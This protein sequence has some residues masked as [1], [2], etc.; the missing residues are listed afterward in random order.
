MV[1]RL[2]FS[3]I[4]LI[5]FFSTN[6]YAQ[7]I[8]I[9][10]R[11]VDNTG[12]TL[13]NCT[14]MLYDKQNN[15]LTSG[16]ISDTDGLFA[17]RVNTKGSY[18]L[19]ISILGFDKNI[20]HL[21]VKD[22][23]I[24]I[25]N[26]VLEESAINLS[27]VSV[28]A[29][30]NE[31]EFSPGKTTVNLSSPLSKASSNILDVLKT[32]PGV[33]IREDGTV[34]LNGQS[35]SQIIVNGK[36]TYLSGENL[37]NLL[38]SMPATSVS[39]IEL[40]THPSAQYDAAGNSGII[41]LHTDRHFF[42]GSSLATHARYTQG[43]YAGGDIGFNFAYRDGKLCLFSD[44]SYYTGKG[45]NDLNVIRE[46]LDFIT[47]K[48]LSDK[49]MYQDT[50]R[51][52]KY[53]SHY[54]RVGLDYDIS[55]KT[56]LGIYSNGFIM[57][58]R[59]DGD[60]SSR[61]VELD[62]IL[63]SELLTNNKN[64]KYPRSYTGGINM[65][66]KPEKET[67]WN[68]YF[69]F[70]YHDQPENQFQYDTF[71]D[72]VSGEQKQD[73]LKGDMGGKIHIYAGESNISFPISKSK[74]RAGAKTSFI[75]VDNSTVYHNLYDNKWLENEALSRQFSYSENINAAYLQAETRFSDRLSTQIGLRVE[76]TN[77]RGT[78]SSYASD[79]DSSY[80]HHYTHLFPSVTLEYKFQ[81]G[82]ALSALYSRRINRPNYNDMNP[83]VYIFDNYMHEQGNPDLEPSLSDN[84]ELSFVWKNKLK[85]SVFLLHVKDPISKSFHL[86]ENDRILVYP[87]NLSSSYSYGLRLNSS[88]FNP[89][90]WW[91]VSA[92][93]T[94][95]YKR[96]KWFFFDKEEKASV[97]SPYAGL[98]N[99]F[100][101]AKNWAAEIYLSYR[102]KNA[103]GQYSFRPVFIGN[104]GIRRQILKEN[105]TISFT[106]DDIF[107][108][109]LLKGKVR[110]P[111]RFYNSRERE[112]GRLFRISF[113][114]RFRKGKE[115]KEA[116]RKRG[117]DERDRI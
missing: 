117:I 47:Q 66:Y 1:N 115:A 9:S 90:L 36:P 37:M 58:R 68:N 19:E 38:R 108:S 8:L 10:G 52:W 78:I 63:S 89:A 7:S 69:D 81:N 39:K 14:V 49:L 31:I 107:E 46:D 18:I 54:Y 88:V 3:V 93:L 6:T 16:L 101:F 85:A 67:E 111:G 82:N 21:E 104:A 34:S 80:S 103:N 4:L 102:G 79:V 40:I 61:I 43:K 22:K 106:I 109:N 20:S 57:D 30:K 41:N 86:E 97:F 11:I 83:F 51:R 112:L 116:N 70:I 12:E 64:N 84:I 35:G 28:T 60:I 25:G 75:S 26:I 48:P 92:N 95:N 76:N 59:Q 71:K 74:I 110:M 96:Y 87:D 65:A 2:F 32:M 113:S 13:P 45:Y 55:P 17:I 72:F 24:D 73:T 105:G 94:L 62:N 23:N 33:F 27:E 42:R 29:S 100:G 53:D 50:Y 5:S 44:Y 56:Y 114:Y 91:K 99:Q 77:V 98:N 15:T